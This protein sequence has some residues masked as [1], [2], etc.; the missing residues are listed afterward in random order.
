MEA[1]EPLSRPAIEETEP[2]TEQVLDTECHDCDCEKDP[3]LFDNFREADDF[4][5]LPRFGAQEMMF[6]RCSI[7]Q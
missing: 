6:A 4:G 2:A 3:A 1:S 5:P 7:R